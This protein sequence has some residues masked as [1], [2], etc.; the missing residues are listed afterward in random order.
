MLHYHEKQSLRSIL[1][2]LPLMHGDA[3]ENL[4]HDSLVLCACTVTS[5]NYEK[6]WYLDLTNFPRWAFN[7]WLFILGHFNSSDLGHSGWVALWC[8]LPLL[9]PHA[10]EH[11]R[12]E[13]WGAGTM[14]E[15]HGTLLLSHVSSSGTTLP[16]APL[17]H[18]LPTQTHK[19]VPTVGQFP[20]SD[21]PS[22]TNPCQSLGWDKSHAM[23]EKKG[24]LRDMYTLIKLVTS[25]TDWHPSALCPTQTHFVE[26]SWHSMYEVCRSPIQHSNF[27]FNMR[28]LYHSTSWT[29]IMAQ[30]EGRWVASRQQD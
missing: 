29:G 2:I 21:C 8:P 10:R 24:H 23:H 20:V 25:G 19:T 15:T 12:E 30:L 9:S 17:K 27:L 16:G 14:N 7:T 1:G 5:W 18:T 6:Q 26:L 11:C 4:S 3:I 22:V 13:L 28:L